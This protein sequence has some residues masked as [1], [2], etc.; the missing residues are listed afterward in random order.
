ML[1][2]RVCSNSKCREYGGNAD[3]YEVSVPGHKPEP[4]VWRCGVVRRLP[5][6]VV[7][8]MVSSQSKIPSDC[9]FVL[10]HIMETQS[11]FKKT[12]ASSA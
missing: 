10:E 12:F 8:G 6:F 4:L 11:C 3:E 2:H 7:D 5:Q 9:K 1:S